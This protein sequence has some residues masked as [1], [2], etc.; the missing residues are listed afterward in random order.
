MRCILEHERPRLECRV[1]PM[2]FGQARY[3][4]APCDEV[5]QFAVVHT[6]PEVRHPPR[7][8]LRNTQRALAIG[9]NERVGLGPELLLQGLTPE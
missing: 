5:Q 2:T 4:R 7:C 3:L 9:D 6:D 8:R 1:A